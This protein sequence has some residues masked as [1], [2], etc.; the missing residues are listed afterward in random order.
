MKLIDHLAD[1]VECLEERLTAAEGFIY[2]LLSRNKPPFPINDPPPK[3]L[4]PWSI[5]DRMTKQQ[6]LERFVN[7]GLRMAREELVEH[8][9]QLDAHIEILEGMI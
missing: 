3:P 2:H 7:E 4:G 8:V 1:R 5:S 6:W 9:L